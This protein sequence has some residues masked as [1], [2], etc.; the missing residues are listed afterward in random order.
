MG[1][2]EG[3]TAEVETALI[4]QTMILAKARALA[5]MKK[6]PFPKEAEYDT[7]MK[8]LYKCLITPK[9]FS[10]N[11][12]VYLAEKL[13]GM[14]KKLGAV[15]KD[16]TPEFIEFATGHGLKHL[17]VKTLKALTQ[18]LVKYIHSGKKMGGGGGTMAMLL[19]IAKDSSNASAMLTTFAFYEK[20]KADFARA[21]AMK[22]KAAIRGAQQAEGRADH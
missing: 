6:E 13:L 10:I 21:K 3:K 12:A 1:F 20:I 16:V 11:V 18:L 19:N 14:A 4:A 17:D 7:K 22:Q 5:M 9:S 8:K 15:P 2:S